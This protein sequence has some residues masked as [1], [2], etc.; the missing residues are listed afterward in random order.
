M[1]ITDSFL[2]KE[3][4]IREITNFSK[5]LIFKSNQL[6]KNESYDIFISH[7]FLDKSLI[8]TL[9]QLF[10]EC[11]YSVYVDWIDDK[12]LDRS[13]VT[14]ETAEIVRSRVS[15]SKSLAYIETKN[16]TNSKWC[17]WELGIADGMLNGRAA[18]LPILSDDNKF[19]G[20]EYLGIYPYIDYEKTKENKKNEF[21]VND[22]NKP[23]A[24]VVLRE[25]LKGNDPIDH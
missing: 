19:K 15:Q 16:I 9:V 22:P 11:G 3:S 17:P 20:Q 18:I 14:K 2:K 21:W 4:Q 24:Y 13:N 7:S 8:L 25:W 23:G 1:I 5:S 10:N 12:T 6:I